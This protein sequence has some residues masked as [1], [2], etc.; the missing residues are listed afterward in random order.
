MCIRDRQST[1]GYHDIMISKCLIDIMECFTQTKES[2]IVICKEFLPT[3]MQ[4]LETVYQ[5]IQASPNGIPQTTQ[6]SGQGSKGSI[7]DLVS[8]LL[9]VLAVFLKSSKDY[10]LSLIHI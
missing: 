9:D 8:G 2:Y 6:Q 3:I 1:W 4:A 10:Q 7:T 5:Q